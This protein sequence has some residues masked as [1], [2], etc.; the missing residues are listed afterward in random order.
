MYL[1]SP[2]SAG[3]YEFIELYYLNRPVLT[4]ILNINVIVSSLI[5]LYHTFGPPRSYSIIMSVGSGIGQIVRGCIIVAVV[6]IALLIDDT[7]AIAGRTSK[8][9]WGPSVAKLVDN[10]GKHK[11]SKF[12]KSE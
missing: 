4:I 9:Q 8:D 1:N 3:T 12:E 7:A 11:C 5:V 10:K 2:L 6:A